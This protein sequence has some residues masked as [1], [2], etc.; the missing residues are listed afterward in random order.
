MPIALDRAAQTRARIMQAAR[1]ALLEGGGDFELSDL[2]RRAGTSVGLPYHRFGSKS[3]V[4]A[5]VVADFYDGIGRAVD[6]ADFAPLDWAVRERER[7]RRLV[8]YLYDDPLS[9]LIIS[10]LARDPA[11]AA[12]E[13]ARWGAL[14]EASGRNLAKAQRR[15]QVA[16]DIDP[17]LTAAMINGGIRHAIGLA[18][19]KRPRCTRLAM[20][21][22]IWNFVSRALRLQTPAPTPMPT[23]TQTHATARRATATAAATGRRGPPR[24]P[25]TRTSTENPR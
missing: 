4:V 14:I 6:L 17:A 16:A 13:T 10:T 15:G 23:P 25:Q 2:A 5:S 1:Q 7:L 11:V 9:G 18:L 20:V 24:T 22:E 19:S 12:L 3:G 21:E 8:D